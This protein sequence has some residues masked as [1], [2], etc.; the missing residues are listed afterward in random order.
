MTGLG[1]GISGIRSDS[2]I[3]C[4]TATAQL[5]LN[6]IEGYESIGYS[7]IAD[8]YLVAKGILGCLQLS[9]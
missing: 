9:W 8:G 7:I 1:P 5:Q 6:K 4:A 2:S 3:L